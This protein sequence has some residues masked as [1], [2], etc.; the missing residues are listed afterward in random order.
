MMYDVLPVSGLF[1]MLALSLEL[2]FR[3]LCLSFRHCC[4]LLPTSILLVTFL[5]CFIVTAFGSFAS[6]SFTVRCKFEITA[7]TLFWTVVLNEYG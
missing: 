5:K 3:Y 6:S 2:H 4:K 1:W 7:I